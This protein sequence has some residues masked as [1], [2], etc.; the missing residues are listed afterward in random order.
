MGAGTT[1]LSIFAD[2]FEVLSTRYPEV[3][4]HLLRQE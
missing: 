4:R 1:A 2:V 3:W